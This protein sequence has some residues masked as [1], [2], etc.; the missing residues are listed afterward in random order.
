MSKAQWAIILGV[1]LAAA[2]LAAAILIFLNAE[3]L[4]QE[5]SQR[6]TQ[7]KSACEIKGQ[8]Y[9]AATL[10]IDLDASP[11]ES[12]ADVFLAD[13]NNPEA[14]LDCPANVSV[15]GSAT[16]TLL[17]KTS[18]GRY[19]A[20]KDT[21][22][23]IDLQEGETYTLEI[24]LEANGS[25]DA[26][27]ELTLSKINLS[28][29]RIAFLPPGTTDSVQI[30]WQDSGMP[31]R[32]TTYWQFSDNPLSETAFAEG[33]FASGC[34]EG[35]QVSPPSNICAQSSQLLTM[36]PGEK[37]PFFKKSFSI[38]YGRWQTQTSG[39]L[40]NATG[41]FDSYV[42]FDSDAA[43]WFAADPQKGCTP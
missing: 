15:I 6:G 16:T 33:E 37:A 20:A 7:G 21:S 5:A 31:E 2:S 32:T 4:P 38:L 41:R 12:S 26:R 1:A 19:R 25:V 34:S 35:S 11:P 22:K 30:Q 10:D 36:G 23:T 29:I 17:P 42:H 39:E 8:L 40:T 13:S 14:P 18:T 28:S 24:D 9:V 27:G 3:S 43:C